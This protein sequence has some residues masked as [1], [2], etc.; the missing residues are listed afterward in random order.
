MSGT[1][2]AF[3]RGPLNAEYSVRSSHQEG[4][5]GKMSWDGRRGKRY[6]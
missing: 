2:L 1:E 4:E 6:C 5:E 3:P